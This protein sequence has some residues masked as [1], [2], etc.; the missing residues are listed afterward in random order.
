MN[1][2]SP[3]TRS[4][5][6]PHKIPRNSFHKYNHHLTNHKASSHKHRVLPTNKIHRD[7]SHPT[8]IK[9]SLHNHDIFFKSH[10]TSNLRLT[11]VKSQSSSRITITTFHRDSSHK[12]PS[13]NPT[14]QIE[15]LLT[16]WAFTSSI[17][18]FKP[19]TNVAI[20]PPSQ[21][22]SSTVDQRCKRPS[23]GSARSQGHRAATCYLHHPSSPN[24]SS[25]TPASGT[26][27]LTT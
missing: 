15:T 6:N 3:K 21:W 4:S 22:V 27:T 23:S 26:G 8:V 12:Y 25:S 5:R 2:P 16:P 14:S 20:C 10:S 1:S 7:S 11:N 9:S 17:N 24:N 18:H 13:T 19:S